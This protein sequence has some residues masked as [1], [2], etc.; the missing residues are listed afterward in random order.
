[1]KIALISDTHWSSWDPG[2]ALTGQLIRQLRQGY[3]EIWHAGDVVDASV[4]EG[5]EQIAPVVCVKGNCD[6][7]IGRALSHSV[8]ATRE[9]VKIAMIHGWDLPLDHSPTVA[10]RFPEEVA[11]IIHGHTHRRRLE[12]YCRPSGSRVTIINPGSASSPR[13]GETPGFGELEV[14]SGSW[15]YRSLP[16]LPSEPF[17]L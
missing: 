3:D 5:L 12:E 9:G 8:T 4:L 15:T 13:G 14:Q 2:R 16:L 17:N 10:G 11:L 7:F 6:S 1:M